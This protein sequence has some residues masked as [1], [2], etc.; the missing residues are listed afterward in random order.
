MG[1]GI[2]ALILVMLMLLPGCMGSDNVDEIE[3]EEELFLPPVP[4]V[5]ITPS[6]PTVDDQITVTIQWYSAKGGSHPYSIYLDDNL[7]SEGN[8]VGDLPDLEILNSTNIGDH[9]ITVIVGVEESIQKS[10]DW[11]FTT[12]ERPVIEPILT[13]PYYFQL[14]SPGWTP[15]FTIELIHP[16]VLSNECFTDF[17]L[18]NSSISDELINYNE[19]IIEDKKMYT[20]VVYAVTNIDFTINIDCGNG[21]ISTGL[22]PIFVND[23]ALADSDGDGI[24]DSNDQCDSTSGYTSSPNTDHDA[25]GCYDYTVDDDDDN[26]GTKD[27]NDRC[28]RGEIN[29]NSSNSAEDFDQDGCRDSSEDMDDDND[30]VLDENDLCLSDSFTSTGITDHDSDGCKDSTEDYDDD[31]DGYD[32]LIDLCPKGSIS[33]IP[34]NITDYDSDGCRDI[35]E[36]SDDDNDTIPDVI[37][38]CDFTTLGSQTVDLNG[39]DDD[40]RDSDS[41]GIV[42]S[43]DIC[44]DT[45]Y[46]YINQINNIGCAD[47][48]SDGVYS[49]VDNCPNSPNRWT[50]DTNGCAIIQNSIGWNTGPYQAN[51][52]GTVGDFSISTTTGTYSFSSSWTGDNTHLFI[53]NYKS[54][55]YM[56]SLWNQDVGQLLANSPDN[57]IIVFGSFDSDYSSDISSMENRVQNW[58][59]NQ[60]QDV[61][62]SWNDRILYMDQRATS[63][64]GSLGDI[65]NEWS[66]FYYGIDRFQRWRQIGNLLDWSQGNSCCYRFH[67]IGN[68]PQMW[69]SEF[70]TQLRPLDPGI[71]TVQVWTGE[72]HQGG[73]GSGYSSFMNASLPDAI[74]MELFDTLEVHHEHRCTDR[75]DRYGIDDDGDGSTDR[76]SGCHEWDRL[77]RMSLC[78]NT[79]SNSCGIEVVRYI[80]TYG[81]E[82]QWTTD[83]SPYLFMFL[84]GGDRRFKYSGAE[85]GNL[86]ITLMFSSWDEDDSRPVRG[87]LAF[88]IDGDKFNSNYNNESTFDRR[89]DVDS[90]SWH[91]VSIVAAIT[92]HGFGQDPNNCAEFCNHEHRYSMNGYDVTEDHPMAGNSSVNSDQQGCRKTTGDGTVANQYGSWPY[93]RAGWCAGLD[94]KL[95][96]YDISHWINPSGTNEL[97][98]QALFDGAEYQETSTNPYIVGTVWIVYEHNMTN[99]NSGAFNSFDSS[100]QTHGMITANP[101]L[102]ENALIKTS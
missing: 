63:S 97:H 42:D 95:W 37:D 93:G 48:D 49:N 4:V 25:D 16:N 46:E 58:L 88:N 67:Y 35:D 87:E 19:L 28:I 76:Y 3:V 12:S 14:D 86:V 51:A 73:W 78:D 22:I 38:Q 59:S 55:S 102:N 71:T 34:S 21:Q 26:D 57:V 43:Q 9:R 91:S 36:D 6:N 54:S 85:G 74:T 24:L 11:T 13:L 17:A 39:C 66:T 60:N 50:I 100:V 101:D 75:R 69:N 72:R 94:V 90:N 20:I 29:W 2:T 31:N 41:D 77:Q 53:F 47:I 79:T 82:G 52:F 80:T 98:Y 96:I 7:I 81:R 45:P 30:N 18:D 65:I 15:Q 62:N 89:H 84:D 92:G 40:Q 56:S 8:T 83:I 1:K 61:Q 44:R 27:A 70:I 64:S 68:E 33:W 23:P 10:A 32:D 99:Q 5:S